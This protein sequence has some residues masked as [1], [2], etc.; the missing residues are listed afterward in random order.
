MTELQAI[1][2]GLAIGGVLNIV[3]EL[4]YGGLVRDLNTIVDQVKE[5]KHIEKQEVGL[6][7]KR[8]C[9]LRALSKHYAQKMVDF[10][11]MMKSRHE[12]K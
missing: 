7:I 9:L 3:Y 5:S 6:H 2:G 1:F 8:Y 12:G 10:G 11:E 4:A